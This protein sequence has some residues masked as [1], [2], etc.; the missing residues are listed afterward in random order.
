MYVKKYPQQ[1]ADFVTFTQKIFNAEIDFLCSDTSQ[2]K[3]EKF[4]GNENITVNIHWIQVNNSI[5]SGCFFIGFIN[6]V[7][8]VKLC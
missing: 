6:I 4:M 7:L 8:K 3:I 5:M 1:T 2:I